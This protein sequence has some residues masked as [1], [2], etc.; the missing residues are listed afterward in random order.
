MPPGA[1]ARARAETSRAI[2]DEARRQLA[3][4]GAAALSLRSVAREVGMVSSA[5]YRYVASRDELL[6]RLIV[7]AYD[8][9]GEAAEG[10]RDDGAGPRAQWRAVWRAVRAWAHEHPAEYGLIYG[11]PVPGYAAPTET[12]PAAGRVGVVLAGIVVAHGDPGA[13]GGW[14]SVVRDDV[15]PELA[16]PVVVPAV[17]AWTQ[18][19]GTVGFELFGQYENV[20]T[21]RDA[22][23]DAVA[24]A[25]ATSVGLPAGR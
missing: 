3:R 24:D 2:L 10:A 5:V 23:F 15:L 4:E 14:P 7:E 21:D 22:Y 13:V 20:V 1:R 9:I 12:I 11:T 25:A 18:L 19:F 17:V 16:R 8:A 6:T